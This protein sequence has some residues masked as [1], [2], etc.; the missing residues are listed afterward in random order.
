VC[1]K[2]HL[3]SFRSL[4]DSVIEIMK[5]KKV[6]GIFCF[7]RVFILFN[8]QSKSSPKGELLLF[9]NKDGGVL[10]KHAYSVIMYTD[11]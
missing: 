8:I 3:K 4:E 1:L 7:L 5:Q 6:C 9:L 11:T 10:T 2:E